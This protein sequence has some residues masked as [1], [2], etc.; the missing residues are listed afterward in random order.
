MC[1]SAQG[2]DRHSM[3]TRIASANGTQVATEL[4]L[5]TR[6]TTAELKERWRYLY[7]I[8]PPARI[9]RGLL[10]RGVGYRLQERAFGG[11]KPSTKRLLERLSGEAG[12]GSPLHQITPS[13]LSAGTVLMRE[14]QGNTHEVTVLEHGLL[15]R[16]KRYRSLSE[17]ARLITGCRWSGPLFFGL[18]GKARG[19]SKSGKHQVG[20]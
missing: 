5:L 13:P 16:K 3:K 4:A 14:W 11:L 1:V 2:R 15:Y 10:V 6:L 18:R 7:D 17:V 8:S 20:A 9:G 19:E 12:S